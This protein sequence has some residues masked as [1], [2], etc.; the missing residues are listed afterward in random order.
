MVKRFAGALAIISVFVIILVPISGAFAPQTQSIS[1]PSANVE[2]INVGGLTGATLLNSTTNTL[3]V[4]VTSNFTTVTTPTSGVVKFHFDLMRTDQGTSAAV[5]SLAMNNPSIYNSTK[6]TNYNYIAQYSSN[7]TNEITMQTP[8]SSFEGGSAIVS[9]PAA[10]QVQVNVTF[11]LNP[12]AFGTANLYST[13]PVT[14]NVL[15]NGVVLGTITINLVETS[16]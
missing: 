16:R 5:F 8:A 6:A 1:T 9:V 10:S 7:K 11:T 4:A 15:E 14:L 13:Q 3:Q 12:E 2:I